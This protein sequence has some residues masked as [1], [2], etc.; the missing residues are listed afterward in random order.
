MSSALPSQLP[1]F[2]DAIQTRR[3]FPRVNCRSC[4]VLGLAPDIVSRHVIMY[5]YFFP[6]QK[7]TLMLDD[8]KQ[9]NT[10]TITDTQGI[11]RLILLFPPGS[12]PHPDA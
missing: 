1:H 8:P 3:S 12:R 5:D 4:E 11:A 6:L 9:F 7:T 2:V 10:G